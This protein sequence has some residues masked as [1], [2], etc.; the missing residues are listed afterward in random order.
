MGRVFRRRDQPNP[1]INK[2]AGKRGSRRKA[3]ADETETRA[4]QAQ[5]QFP[6]VERQ[7]HYLEALM[8][9]KKIQADS[10][11][12]VRKISAAAEAENVDVGSL[13]DG[14]KLEK[15][16]MAALRRRLEQYAM[17]LAEK[18]APFQLTIFDTMFKSS[19]DQA[20]FEGRQAAQAGRGAEC[21]YPEGSADHAIFMQAYSETQAGFVPGAEK[22][23]SEDL[24][25]AA[26]E[27]MA[28]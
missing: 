20:A 28:H 12:R 26:R 4:P 22:A 21:R 13:N 19:A 25:S 27:G 18:G 24:K 15:A 14:S 3:Q 23:T 16:D 5:L 10:R 9:E 11:A 1:E 17:L 6:K 2:M 8:A 7:I